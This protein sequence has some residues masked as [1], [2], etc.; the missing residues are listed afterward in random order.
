MQSYRQAV[1][2]IPGELGQVLQQVSDSLAQ[3]VMEIRLRTGRIPVLTLKDKNFPLPCNSIP[4]AHTLQQLLETLC[5]YSVYS[6]QESIRQGYITLSGGHRVG[7]AGKA[8][9]NAEIITGV[10]PITSLNIRI[11]RQ[12]PSTLPQAIQQLI[13]T[14]REGIVVAGAPASGKTTVLKQI[15]WQISQQNRRVCVIDE[16]CELSGGGLPLHCDVLQNCQK[17]QGLLWAIRGLSPQVLICDEIG[18]KEDAQAVIMAANAGVQLIVSMHGETKEQL[19]KRPTCRQV[20]ETGAF[21]KL[22]FLQ[23]GQHLGQVGQV[24]CI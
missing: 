3:Q 10:Q 1:E 19:L 14:E 18:D 13:A 24:I 8:I 20:L 12:A 17:S 9:R 11:A 4:N 23:Q 22:L 21:S 16:R 15:I 7:I 5:S 6:W 2:H